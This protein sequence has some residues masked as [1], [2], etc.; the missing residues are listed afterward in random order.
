MYKNENRPVL[1]T[2]L[3][4]QV[5]VNQRQ[6]L[7]PDTLNLIEKKVGNSLVC[8][9]TGDNFPNRTLTLHT[10]CSTINKWDLMKLKSF[11]KAKNTTNLIKR[12]TTKWETF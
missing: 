11:Y 10:L 5:Q 1:I 2:L 3:K 6:Q 8:I 9:G 4:T 12:Q 7:K